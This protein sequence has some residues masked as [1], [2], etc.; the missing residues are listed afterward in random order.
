MKILKY[1][2]SVFVLTAATLMALYFPS[3]YF[4]KYE[5]ETV[6]EEMEQHSY[7]GLNSKA[8]ILQISKMMKDESYEKT[9][10]YEHKIEKTEAD[11]EIEAGYIKIVQSIFEKYINCV[12]EGIKE[13]VD[14]IE[15][16]LRRTEWHNMLQNWML[17]W[18]KEKEDWEVD[19][20]LL[21]NLANIFSGELI[22]TQLCNI[23]LTIPNQNT[24]MEI[25]FSPDTQVFYAIYIIDNRSPFEKK[26]EEI[27]AGEIEEMPFELYIY[28]KKQGEPDEILEQ[29]LYNL[30]NSYMLE[31]EFCINIFK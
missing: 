21:F 12:E 23:F 24:S 30:T 26:I 22:Y 18:I 19:E 2:A 4:E 27:P 31:N 17:D 6:I 7:E 9:V 10:I 14:R 25:Y 13:G 1:I 15:S 28:Y 8:N 16:E 5:Y 20:V 29:C 11:R 3:V